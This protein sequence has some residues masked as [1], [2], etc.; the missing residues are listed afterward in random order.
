VQLAALLLDD[1][2]AMRP[3]ARL[4]APALGAIVGA[5]PFLG[6]LAIYADV[7]A[8]VRIYFVDVPAMY[9]F[10]WARTPGEIFGMGNNA[11]VATLAIATSVALVALVV[12]R[13]LPR[14]ALAIALVPAVGLVN[15]TVQA[16]G[17]PYHFHPVTAGTHLAWLVVVAWLADRARTRAR[18][19]NR[20]LEGGARAWDDA[21]G[22]D[23]PSD[24]ASLTALVAAGGLA[25][26]IGF[27]LPFSTYAQSLWLD[28][29]ALTAE[30]RESHDYLVYFRTVDF[31]PWEM[32]QTAR[33]LQAHTK[34]DDRVQTYGMDPYVLFLARRKSATPYIYAY[35]LNA[36]AALDGGQLPTEAGG[37][38]PSGAEQARIRALRDAHED[39]LV[40]RVTANPPAAWVF[41]DRA[42][43]M[44]YGNAMHDFDE[45]CPK[46]S[47]WFHERYL[48]KAT[49]G[50][51][52]V[53]LRRDLAEGLANIRDV[54]PPPASE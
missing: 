26:K 30:A 50:D 16:K 28:A 29:K 7:R 51:D 19:R 37:L 20:E 40:A 49:F 21:N 3:L 18:E 45:H 54:P 38:H 41:F 11:E 1:L 9:R 43:L 35:D 14:R 34:P 39:D 23:R 24:A 12:T 6:Y 22:P 33:Y 47:A 52:H 46:A 32:R 4:R 25:L 27:T 15:V 10:M 42:P 44:S 53:W 31:F 5:L 48:E 17:F 36:D 2:P 8:F 13:H